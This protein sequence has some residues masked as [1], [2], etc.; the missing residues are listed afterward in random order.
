MRVKAT[1]YFQILTIC[2]SP[3][4]RSVAH[5]WLNFAPGECSNMQENS[6]R[7]AVQIL[8]KCSNRKRLLAQSSATTTQFH[9]VRM[10]GCKLSS[11]QGR[12]NRWNL[13]IGVRRNGK[14]ERKSGGQKTEERKRVKERDN[15]SSY[16]SHCSLWDSFSS[17]FG[18]FESYYSFWGS[19]SICVSLAPLLDPEAVCT[20][21][22]SKVLY[23]Y[24]KNQNCRI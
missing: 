8:F 18:S 20:K 10:W 24:L 23:G 7:S 11:T 12:T 15:F 5:K 3:F 16:L 14:T 1:Q 2:P 4:T 21:Q 22:I 13:G 9:F 17:L 6:S 19:L